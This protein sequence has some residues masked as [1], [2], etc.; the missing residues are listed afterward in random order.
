MIIYC[1]TKNLG[2]AHLL[3]R[4]QIGFNENIINALRNRVK[5]FSGNKKFIEILIDETKIHSNLVW[6]KHTGEVDVK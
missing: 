2:V 6:D 3:I 5:D 1:M 4:P